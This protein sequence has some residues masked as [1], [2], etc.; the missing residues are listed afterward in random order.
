[1]GE[2]QEEKRRPGVPRY[3]YWAKSPPKPRKVQTGYVN[4]QQK[5]FQLVQLAFRTAQAVA[6]LTAFLLF[7]SII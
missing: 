3:D 7:F 1:M 5:R 6:V 2:E 4:A